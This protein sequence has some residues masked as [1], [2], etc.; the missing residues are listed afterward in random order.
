MK[1][2]KLEKRTFKID[3]LKTRNMEDGTEATVIEGYASVFNSPT[4]IADWYQEEIADGAF[5]ETLA[6]GKDARALFNHNWDYV[7]GRVSAGTLKLEEDSHGLRFEV[8]IPDTSFAA[9]LRISM[10]RGDI[11]QCSFGFVI[12]EEETNYEVEPMQVRILKVELYEVSIVSLPAYEDTVASLR[13]KEF[14]EDAKKRQ[15]I[16][17]KISEVLG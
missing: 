14:M 1:L 6:S 7:L 5:A 2:D 10:E 11:N 4:M 12:L 13:S 3:N 15:Q 17:K 8:T 9:D 16:I